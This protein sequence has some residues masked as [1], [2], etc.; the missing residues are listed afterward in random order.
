LYGW[1]IIGLVQITNTI[2]KEWYD[3]L[4]SAGCLTEIF[5]LSIKIL[6]GTLIEKNKSVNGIKWT[7]KQ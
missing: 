7:M 6:P 3:N 1:F 2:L 4:M 5:L